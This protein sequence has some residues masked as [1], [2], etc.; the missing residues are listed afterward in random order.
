MKYAFVIPVY[1][2]GDTLESVVIALKKY[3]IPIIIVDDGNDVVNKKYISDVASHYSETILITREKNG[4]KGAAVATAVEY[5]YENKIS[6]IF[7]IDA[8]GQHDANRCGYFLE[9][10][11]E[12]PEALICGYPVYDESA[13]SSRKNGRVV[14][15]TW[16]KIVTLSSVIID[17]MCG[18][19]VYPVNP[20]YK[21]MKHASFDKRMGFDI[22]ILV[23]LMWK[24]VEILSAP[25][26]VYY[27]EN[28]VSNFHVIRD[29]V[30]ISGMFTRL[31]FGMIL[32]S[33]Y[34]ITLL[35][36]R[37]LQKNEKR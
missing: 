1:N 8:D 22:E 14:A 7:Q 26:S 32:R 36:K 15:N 3:N 33:P 20:F 16:V 27:P 13:P 37:H 9:K 10:S 19:R 5:A 35:I 21:I 18:F 24:N 4:G 31:F 11:K 17:S 2:H 28:A 25:V 30:F 23:R 29:N 6:H 34:L 12:N